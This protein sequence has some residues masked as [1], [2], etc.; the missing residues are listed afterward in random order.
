MSAEKH[1]SP[2]Y[3]RDALLMAVLCVGVLV[4]G[5][6][7]AIAEERAQTLSTEARFDIWEYRIAGNTLLTTDRI[8]GAVS[9]YLGPQRLI[10]DVNEAA[11]NLERAYREAGYPTIYVDVPEQDVVGGIVE[12]KVV[13]G[14]LDRVRIE[15]A[16]YFTLS[17]IRNKMSSLQPG[18]ALH[19]PTMQKELA[20]LNALSPDMK[21]V[22][23]LKP[24]VTPGA[25]DLDLKVNDQRP[26]HGSIEINNYSS[27]NTTDTR[28]SFAL[29]YDNL[30]QK[31]HSF[32]L[33]W[34]V[35]PEATDEVNVLVGTYIAPWFDTNKR[36]AFYMV[37][38]NSDVASVGDINV[39]GDGRI[40]GV[41][42]VIP[43]ES[44]RSFV[45]SLSM[46]ADYKDYSEIIRLDP[47]NKIATPIDYAT[48]TFQY[49]A[50]AFSEKS[51]T[52]WTIG[53]TF[54]IRGVGN[55]DDEFFDKRYNAR[56]NFVYLNASMNRTDF[57]PADWQ[58]RTRFSGQIADSPLIN[59]E[60][61]S[62]GGVHSVRGYYESQ[63]LGDNGV[64]GSLELRTPSFQKSVEKISNFRA[65]AFIEGAHLQV[66]DALPDQEDSFDIASVGLGLVLQAFE[67]LDVSLDWGYALKDSNSI[68]RG[69]DRFNAGAE[70]KF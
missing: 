9:P 59:N 48:W 1:K 15:G 29:S 18:Q 58:L 49:N 35:S 25:V 26:L 70:W 19:V 20:A 42:Y 53:T 57:L 65:L 52:Q 13:E 45:H 8:E 55:S 27:A 21:V 36:I 32:G 64:S 33:Q 63:T 34:Q 5:I 47:E 3:W 56:S 54:G 40:Y 6:R 14:R 11:A 46:G 67:K 41:R 30:W 16:R 23:V 28:A 7:D 61:F 69:D 17:G 50:S 12:L 31:Q 4:L 38:S 62:A 24:G 39:I 66:K 2:S 51:Q 44:D 43:L 10:G 68:E 22:P 37:D 60:Q